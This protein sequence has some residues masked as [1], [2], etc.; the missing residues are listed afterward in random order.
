MLY[1]NANISLSIAAA[2]GNEKT[3]SGVDATPSA[4]EEKEAP[5]SSAEL[6]DECATRAAAEESI[7]DEAHTLIVKSYLKLA[8][9]VLHGAG[10]RSKDDYTRVIQ[11]CNNVRL[12]LKIL[13]GKWRYFLLI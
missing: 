8:E 4:T 3:I 12:L 11:Y 9:C 7:R 10:G 5:I 1:Q 2:V 6:R 13:I